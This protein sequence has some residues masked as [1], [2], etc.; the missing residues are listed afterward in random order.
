[1]IKVKTDTCIYTDRQT[2]IAQIDTRQFK[3][4]KNTEVKGHII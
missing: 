2:S 1:M 4:R 3:Q